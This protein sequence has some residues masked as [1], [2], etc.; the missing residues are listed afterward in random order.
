[1]PAAFP[2]SLVVPL[3][4]LP[5]I[6]LF[7]G[8]LLP[9][10][11]FEPRYCTMLKDAMDSRRLIAMAHIRKAKD[12]APGAEPGATLA[13]PVV[14]EVLGVGSIVAH[15]PQADGTFNIALLGQAR[16]RI[17]EE[18]P[19]QIYRLV[20]VVTLHD[21]VPDT[22]ELRTHLERARQYLVAEAQRLISRTLVKEAAGQLK[23]VLREKQDAGAV[24]DLLTSVYVNDPS[25]KQALLETLDVLKRTQLTTA[26]VV[27]ILAGLEP[28][29]PPSKYGGG[30]VSLN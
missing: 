7:P 3:F 18:V 11:I 2:D 19:H 1:M 15:E 21:E 22:P 8:C 9:L 10:R 23:A 17:E 12:G 29:P 14:H 5:G 28:K 16:C 24:A 30:D 26:M 4:P 6:V 13:P 25:L 20:R 27:K